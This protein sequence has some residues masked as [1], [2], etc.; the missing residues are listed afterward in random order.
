[1]ITSYKRQGEE[2]CYTYKS[3]MI[4]GL[5]QQSMVPGLLQKTSQLQLVLHE[6]DL[7]KRGGIE[8]RR[9]LMISIQHR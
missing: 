2:I 3:A 5:L 1:M 4:E 6:A 7:E 8:I 9:R